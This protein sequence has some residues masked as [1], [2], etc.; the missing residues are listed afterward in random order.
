MLRRLVLAALLAVAPVSTLAQPQGVLHIRVVLTD[1][2]GVST[3]V[4]R[5]ALL[6]SDNPGTGA[7]RRVVTAA[8]GTIDVRLPPGNYTVE[9]ETAVAF[10]G[11][12]YEWIQTLDVGAGA[13]VVL[14]LTTANA[15]VGAPPAATAG[16]ASDPSLLL[17]Q[18]KDSLVAV[19]TPTSRASGFIV[20]SRGLVLTN[21]RA[22]GL[23]QATSVQLSPSVKVE[24]RVLAAD[25]RRDVAVLWID[26]AAIGAV[27]PWPMSCADIVAVPFADWQRVIALGLPLRGP[28]DL[29]VG[30]VLPSDTGLVIADVRLASGS[31][32]GP[33]F[34]V[35]GTVVG[36]SSNVESQDDRRRRDVRI[37]PAAAACDT[38]QDARRA[39]ETM[40]APSAAHL[41]VEPTVPFP[42]A[43]MDAAPPAAGGIDPYRLAT[44]EFDVAFITPAVVRN[45][46]RLADSG[47]TTSQSLQ[48]Q[49]NPVDLTDFGEWSD[50][51]AGAPAVVVIRV[52]PK[53]EEGWWTRVAR[54]AAYTQGVA[55]PPIRRFKPGFAGLRVFCGDTVVTPIHPFM[56][57][58]R[59]SDTDAVR[60]G[61]Y[62]FEPQA[63]GPHC[64]TVTLRLSSEKAPDKEDTKTVDRRIVERMWDDLAPHR[65]A[66]GAVT[67]PR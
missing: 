52:T 34:G 18:W 65:L 43:T 48:M 6:I 9:S 13:D 26:S 59:V 11:Q 62:V 39:M 23:A 1:A 41:P 7:P 29:S 30:E 10:G 4:P 45:A 42:T 64:A 55:L 25:A 67:P 53:F 49:G 12:G 50:Y 16:T 54:G 51:F 15:D 46:R 61:L 14:A 33:V 58:Q 57:E 27:K 56:L 37:V 35:A 3:P 22:V 17:P 8:D 32:G 2:S 5:H 36:L 20:D 60:E 31:L 44:S 40:Q 28:I 63:L 38:L 24:A 66:A 21:Q 19:W 47:R